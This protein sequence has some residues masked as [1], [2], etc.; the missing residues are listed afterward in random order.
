MTTPNKG[1]ATIVTGTRAGLWGDDLNTDVFSIIDDNLGGIVTKSVAGSNITLTS[2][3]AQ[4]CIIRLTGAQSADIQVTNPCIGFYFVENLTTN[5]F[6][7][8]V[9]NGVAGVVVPKGRSTIIADSTNGCRIAGTD[10]FPTGTKMTFLNASA[11]TGWTKDP[12]LDDATIR[13]SSS[14]GGTTGG[15]TGFLTAFANNH[16]LDGAT[17]GF[18]LQITHLAAHT[19]QVISA[20]TR[21]GSQV[22]DPGN[23]FYASSGDIGNFGGKAMNSNAVG[24]GTPH[25][26]GA[27]TLAIDL[28]VKYI[29]AIIAVKN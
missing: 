22:Q 29:N 21:S 7:I 24:S 19:H 23:N 14:A 18:S 27:G 17:A 11:P 5:S 20:G 2:D 12:S 16:S 9:T 6:N 25:S 8:T 26:H 3:E 15:S 10:S 4:N 13:I 28:G 1:Y